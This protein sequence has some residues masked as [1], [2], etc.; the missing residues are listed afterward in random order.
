MLVKQGGSGSFFLGKFDSDEAALSQDYF[1][2][3]LT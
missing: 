3:K 2:H 1:N